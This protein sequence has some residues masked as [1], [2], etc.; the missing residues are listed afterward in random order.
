M[1]TVPRRFRLAVDVGGT[2]TDG[3]LI[4]EATGT[5]WAEK[6]PTTPADPAVGFLSSVRRLERRAGLAPGELQA[7]IHGTTVA[8][9]ALLERRGARCGLIVTE[10]FR[11]IL[12]IGRQIRHELYNL[13]T[14]KPPP[15]IPR[16][17]CVG[18]PERLDHRGDVLEPLDPDAVRRAVEFLRGEGVESIAVCLLHAYRNAA[19]ERQV[20][21]IIRR[22]HPAATISLSSDIAPEIREYWRAST[23]VTNAYIAP[24]VNRYL[25]AIERSLES[26]AA[27]A[28]FHVMQSNGG[29]MPAA[30][31]RRRPIYMLESGP[32]AGVTAAAHITA[33]AAQRDAISFDMGGTTAKMGLILGGQPRVVTEFE[34]GATLGSGAGLA[35]GSGYPILAPVMDLVEIGAGGGSLAWIDSG[36]L[37]R[38][39]PR[40]AGA[41][42]GPACYGRGGEEPTVTDANLLLGRLN[43]ENFLGGQMP[44]DVEAARR[45]VHR[46]CAGPLGV[47]PVRAAMGIVE[48]ADAT[49]VAAMRLVTVQRGHDPAGFCLVSFG[50]AGPAHANQLAAELGIPVVLIPPGPGVASALGMLVSDLRHEYRTTRLQPLAEASLSGLTS[51]YREF[52]AMAADELSAEGV[53]RQRVTFERYADMR[54]VGQ[55]WKLR[56]E[57][58]GGDLDEADRPRLREAFDRLH[59]ESYGYAVPGEPIEIVNLGAIAVGSITRPTLWRPAKGGASSAHARTANRP[60][61]FEEAEGFVDC[62][63]YDRGRL[64][65]GNHLSG[66]AVIEEPDSTTLVHPGH[67]VEVGQHGILRLRPS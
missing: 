22:H 21:E 54:Y 49:M 1:T 43:P 50:G 5:V 29:I 62:P 13:Q 19:H 63:I 33:L 52:E 60:V 27:K 28:S 65:Q 47:D 17:R 4:D 35:K 3:V 32:A 40:S 53:E 34:A 7:I 48:I 10:G 9:N 38:I 8:T 16:E 12:E 18:V 26:A 14:E 66:P 11:D 36:G 61:F 58:P 39:G 31:A 15:L 42:P 44:L 67:G 24:I 51:Q 57:V 55:S 23:A 56:V 46:R 59:R 30:A 6:L 20:A 45:A 41:D 25:G 64:A 37:L 2:F